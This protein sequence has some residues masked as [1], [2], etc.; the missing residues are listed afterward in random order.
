MHAHIGGELIAT[1]EMLRKSEMEVADLKIKLE[2]AQKQ[3]TV[4]R[5]APCS[6]LH[7]RGSSKPRLHWHKRPPRPS[8]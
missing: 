5:R 1:K 2:A 4:H 8:R 7:G 3:F 6:L